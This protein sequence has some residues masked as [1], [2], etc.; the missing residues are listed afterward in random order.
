M[1]DV[2]NESG[3][4][5]YYQDG[6]NVNALYDDNGMELGGYYEDP[7]NPDN[8][9]AYLRAGDRSGDSMDFSNTADAR[10]WVET[11]GENVFDDIYESKEV[12][13]SVGWEKDHRWD[14]ET[15]HY[16]T[17]GDTTFGSV[18]SVDNDGDWYYYARVKGKG[19]KSFRGK[20]A[21]DNAKNW[22]EQNVSVNEDV[23]VPGGRYWE[24]G[25]ED[26]DDD[27]DLVDYD[28]DDYDDVE[29]PF[30]SDSPGYYEE[31]S[32][33]I[34]IV[35]ESMIDMG[36]KGK[37]VSNLTMGDL[38]K[39]DL[40]DEDRVVIVDDNGDCRDVTRIFVDEDNG[41]LYLQ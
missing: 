14:G 10:E 12:S 1:I 8:V 11:L 17:D 15:V 32:V 37:P 3:W 29:L 18:E 31:E 6:C 20:D 38:R 2:V 27:R 4:E 26:A 23:H 16:F 25:W 41:W 5:Q 19:N 35:V 7:T 30:D 39:M 9:H 36:K 28:A 22:V 21:L 13:E 33:G 34:P 40:W 24:P